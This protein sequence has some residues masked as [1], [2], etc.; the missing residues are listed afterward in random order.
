MRL[1]LILALACAFPIGGLAPV[2]LAAAEN[3]PKKPLPTQ[4]AQW[5]VIG[6]AESIKVG[7]ELT[8]KITFRAVPENAKMVKVDLHWVDKNGNDKGVFD[9]MATPQ[10]AKTKGTADF[11]FTIAARDGL[12]SVRPVVYTSEDGT[13]GKKVDS[14]RATA[15]E[16][17]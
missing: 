4:D 7:Q 10:P 16:V 8:V 12:G 5:A 14:F 2:T 1:S 15:I 6:V 17:R 9:G 11:R 3:G 13:W